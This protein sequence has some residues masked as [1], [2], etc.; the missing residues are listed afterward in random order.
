MSTIDERLGS[1]TVKPAFLLTQDELDCNPGDK[2]VAFVKAQEW[3]DRILTGVICREERAT[4]EELLPALREGL[5]V[6]QRM[7]PGRIEGLLNEFL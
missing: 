3:G 7:E 4:F 1:P 2:M 5:L 6:R